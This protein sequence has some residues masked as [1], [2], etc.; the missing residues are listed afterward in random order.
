[1]DILKRGQHQTFLED[2]WFGA[3]ELFGGAMFEDE[4]RF[5]V[6]TRQRGAQDVAVVVMPNPRAVGEAY[7]LGLV[8]QPTMT[9]TGVLTWY[10]TL[11]LG[12]GSDYRTPCTTLACWEGNTRRNHGVGPAAEPEAFLAEILK[13]TSC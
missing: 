7:M 3:A 11:E 12:M 13:R 4:L 5:D 2:L 8:V 10:Y 9:P 6:Y 1:M